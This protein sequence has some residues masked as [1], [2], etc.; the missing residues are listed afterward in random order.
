MSPPSPDGRSKFCLDDELVYID[1]P[2]RPTTDSSFSPEIVSFNPDGS[3]LSEDQFSI[4]KEYEEEESIELARRLMAEEAMASYEHH[5]Q[6]LRESANLLSQE[7][8]DALQRA[9]EENDEDESGTGED[10]DLSYDFMLELGERIGDVKTERWTMIAAAE[11]N[12]L[13]T[14]KFLPPSMANAAKDFDDNECRCL[15]CQFEYEQ[16]EEIRR[17]PCGHCFHKSCVDVW[18]QQRDLCPYCRQ[19]IVE[20]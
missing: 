3:T 2:K 4:R 8:Y 14:F 1:S 18:L 15:I 6:L 13:P 5:F 20:R 7:D 19:C 10:Q 17:L 12:R 11:I 9:L 16:N